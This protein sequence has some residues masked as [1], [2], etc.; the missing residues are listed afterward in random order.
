[1]DSNFSREETKFREALDHWFKINLPEDIHQ[2]FI[3]DRELN[4]EHGAAM[5]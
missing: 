3:G 2:K 5:Q 4:K 1:M